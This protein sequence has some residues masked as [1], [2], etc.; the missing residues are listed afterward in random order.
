MTFFEKLF[1]G[2]DTESKLS[3]EPSDELIDAY[4]NMAANVQSICQVGEIYA[5]AADPEDEYELKQ[6][7]KY[8]DKAI[9]LIVLIHDEFLQGFSIHQ[10]SKFCSEANR[11]EIAKPF[12]DAISDEFI[13]DKITE[14][15]PAL[16]AKR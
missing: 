1:G 3:E 8:K 13:R 15:V 4:S 9:T 7:E 5:R 16:G 6:F 10:F 12:F 2:A 14:D 11:L